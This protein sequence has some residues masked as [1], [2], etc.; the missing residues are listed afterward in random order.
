MSVKIW[1]IYIRIE[2]LFGEIED[3]WGFI[4]KKPKDE[5]SIL[6]SDFSMVVDYAKYQL[7]AHVRIFY[8]VLRL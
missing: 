4:S 8:R 5:W 2:D 1:R 3:L 7:G 6:S